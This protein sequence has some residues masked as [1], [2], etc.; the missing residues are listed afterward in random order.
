M[1]HQHA[2]TGTIN[3]AWK[4]IFVKSI[5]ERV[6]V[7]ARGRGK[8]G[9][10]C[11]SL[12]DLE[13]VFLLSLSMNS[14]CAVRCQE[15]PE[16]LTIDLNTFPRKFFILITENDGIVRTKQKTCIAS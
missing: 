16:L 4:N 13:E 15:T 10:R 9:K 12:C 14:T 1:A 11:T 6:K 7:D 5:D 3:L 8:G 2:V